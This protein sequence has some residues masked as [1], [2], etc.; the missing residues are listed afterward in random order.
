MSSPDRSFERTAGGVIAASAVISLFALSFDRGPAPGETRQI[1]EQLAALAPLRGAVH[2]VQLACLVGLA[3]GY[4]A[5]AARLDLR[6]PAVLAGLVAFGGGCLAMMVTVVFDGFIT[7]GVA[8]R[9]A[10]APAEDM[11]IARDL[12]RFCGI[13]IEYLGDVA[14]ALMAA[15]TALW[16]AL[17][18]RS[19]GGSRLAGLVGL[20]VGSAT[21]AAVALNP[22]LGLP[23]LMAIIA[24]QMLWYLASAALLIRGGVQS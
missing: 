8:A 16:A 10:A 11:E 2:A 20:A 5:F 3:A 6:R 17:L 1:L 7:Q 23:M 4:A 19:P 14:F 21:L 12:I 9:F 13:V 24:G 22:S 15:G 18:C